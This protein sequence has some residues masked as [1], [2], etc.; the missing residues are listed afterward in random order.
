MRVWL[1]R[2]VSSPNLSASFGA[3]A[4]AQVWAADTFSY[5]QNVRLINSLWKIRMRY[6][7]SKRRCRFRGE[8]QWLASA[9]SRW[10]FGPER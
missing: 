7:R 5:M 8:L 10:R 2:G 9:E 1:M 6:A 3:F 4:R